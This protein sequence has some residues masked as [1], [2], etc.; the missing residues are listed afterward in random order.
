M[1]HREPTGRLHLTRLLPTCLMSLLE[2]FN[3]LASSKFVHPHVTLPREPYGFSQSLV[4]RYPPSIFSGNG[5]A[6][7]S[8]VFVV[9]LFQPVSA[10]CCPETRESD[11][12]SPDNVQCSLQTS[13][14]KDLGSPDNLQLFRPQSNIRDV[15]I[16]GVDV[17]V[18]SK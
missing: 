12:I 2:F 13:V 1:D 17:E 14:C 16:S 5:P 8:I 10:F 11:P 9:F 4:A 6:D 18:C 3:I 7:S 15:D